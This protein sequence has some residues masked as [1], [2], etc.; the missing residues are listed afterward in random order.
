MLLALLYWFYG[1]SNNNPRPLKFPVTWRMG[2]FSGNVG[3]FLTEILEW[4]LQILALVLL[5]Q[6]MTCC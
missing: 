2:L 1:I 6:P 5:A 3:M 4:L